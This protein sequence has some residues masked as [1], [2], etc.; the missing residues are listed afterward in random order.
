MKKFSE[1]LDM[2]CRQMYKGKE[3]DLFSLIERTYIGLLNNA[4]VRHYGNRATTLQEFSVWENQKIVGRADLLV[5]IR[6]DKSSAY[7]LFEGKQREFDGK[8]YVSNE[9]K[10]FFDAFEN[11]ARK[12]YDAEKDDYDEQVYIVPIVFEWIRTQKKLTQVLDWER[13]KDDDHT[14]FYMV[15][16]SNC[17]GENNSGL[18]VYGKVVK[19]NED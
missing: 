8:E 15:L 14:D 17:E 12:Y 4:I 13:D 1:E 5:K 16:H 7:F 2:L 9:L 11:Q 10:T 6:F 19:A 3:A 18:M